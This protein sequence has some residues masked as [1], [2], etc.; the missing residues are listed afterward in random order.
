[1]V[2]TDRAGGAN[3][4]VLIFNQ[5]QKSKLSLWGGTLERRILWLGNTI[6]ETL[7]E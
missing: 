1:M 4:T 2:E 5:F 3:P 7:R 6:I